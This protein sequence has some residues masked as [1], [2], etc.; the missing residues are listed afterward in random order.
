LGPDDKRALR[1]QMREIR[2]LLPPA[3]RAAAHEAIAAALDDLHRGRPGL[4]GAYAPGPF[5]ASPLAFV[6]RLEG[7]GEQVAWPRVDGAALR[8]HVGPS[9]GLA[10][11]YAGLLEPPADWPEVGPESLALLLVPGLA[12]DAG[13]ARLGQGGGFYDRLLGD[14]HGLRV[15]VCYA[16]QRVARVPT[17]AH[18]VHVDVVVSD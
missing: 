4:V 8:L 12:F 15:G 16:V 13:G 2:R 11:G 6:H 7:R 9:S 17:L 10:P 18:D 1:A 14:I 3:T 5:E